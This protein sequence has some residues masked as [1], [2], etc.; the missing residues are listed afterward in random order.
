[1]SKALFQVALF[2]RAWIEMYYIL[3]LLQ[4]IGVALFTR[5][6]IEIDYDLSYS[7]P[8]M[9]PSLRGRGLKY[10]VL[11][12]SWY[13]KRVALFTRAWIEIHKV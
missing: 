8:M 3:S 11:C 12:D 7:N 2:T 13:L 1:M 5:A 10:V 4:L 9:S 6:W